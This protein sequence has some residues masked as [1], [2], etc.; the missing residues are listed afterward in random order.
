MVPRPLLHEIL[1][2]RRRRPAGG[3][4]R[5]LAKMARPPGRAWPP[6]L[7]P[8]GSRWSSPSRGVPRDARPRAGGRSNA[9][10]G[11]PGCGR[12]GAS[13][14][15]STWGAMHIRPSRASP[16]APARA[17]AP[18]PASETGKP[19]WVPASATL[20]CRSTRARSPR[21][22]AAR[23]WPAPAPRSPAV[24]QRE[25]VEGLVDL[26]PLQLPHQ[27]PAH[28]EGAAGAP[29]PPLPGR[30]SPPGPL[31]RRRPRRS[32]QGDRLGD[33]YQGDGAGS[34]PALRRAG[35]LRL[36]VRQRDTSPPTPGAVPRLVAAAGGSSLHPG[37]CVG[38]S[39]TTV[40]TPSL[41]PRF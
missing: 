15:R 14:R 38:A 29:S 2:R 24:D 39:A 35:D 1:S 18:A 8:R 37:L 10:R 34:R 31:L 9:R 40:S 33:R 3:W 32:A 22:A 25:Q 4:R 21:R 23:R 5:A 27:V 30:G 6:L 41:L 7:R 26:V 36:D 12:R 16:G 11:W 17:R 13:P 19:P 28:A 20:T